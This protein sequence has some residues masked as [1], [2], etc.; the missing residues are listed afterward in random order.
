MLDAGFPRKYFFRP[1][2]IHPTRPRAHPVFYDPLMK[3]VF[4][5][6]PSLGIESADLAWVMIQ[7]GLS[8]PRPVAVLENR[9]MLAI[10]R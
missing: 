5:L 7:T 4:R 10:R 3:P 6:F 2:Y 1:A 8:D 9:E